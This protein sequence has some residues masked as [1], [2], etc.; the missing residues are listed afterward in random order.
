MKKFIAICFLLLL[1][2]CA[3]NEPEFVPLSL[4]W[5]L[6]GGDVRVADSTF[7]PATLDSAQEEKCIIS[8]TRSLMNEDAIRQ[9]ANLGKEFDVQYFGR[10]ESGKTFA[11]FRGTCSGD[12]RSNPETEIFSFGEP[13]TVKDCRFTARCDGN[14]DIKS[15]SVF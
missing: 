13:A 9:S 5:F 6:Y 2:G 1:A 11:E 15:L 12:V 8:L 3:K 14:G 4:N 10:S 7:V